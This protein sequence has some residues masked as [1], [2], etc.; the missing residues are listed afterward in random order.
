MCIAYLLKWSP[1]VMRLTRHVM[2]SFVIEP[3]KIRKTQRKKMRR[4]RIYT[5]VEQELCV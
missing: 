3:E 2:V 5:E 4:L 1:Y